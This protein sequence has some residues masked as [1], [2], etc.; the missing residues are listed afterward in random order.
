MNAL[1]QL[2]QRF[3]SPRSPR[4]RLGLLLLAGVCGI[5]AAW[6]W[7]WAPAWRIWQAAPAQ[8]AQ[9]ART[10]QSLS[11]LQAQALALQASAPNAPLRGAELTTWLQAHTAQWLGPEAQVRSGAQGIEVVVVRASA[12]G[13][14]QWLAQV[15]TQARLLPERAEL[16]HVAGEPGQAPAWRGTLRL[17]LP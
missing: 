14:A 3:W 16:E 7:G 8:Q 2:A 5:G 10:S 12:P 9:A 13:L 1:R 4:E 6:T 15:R 11:A 17:A